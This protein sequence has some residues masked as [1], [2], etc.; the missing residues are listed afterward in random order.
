[1]RSFRGRRPMR[2]AIRALTG[3]IVVAALAAFA[4]PAAGDEPDTD[5][6]REATVRAAYD[7]AFP[8][9]FL[10]KLRWQ[11]LETSGGRT[12]TVL[13]QFAHSR[14]IAGPE[15]KWA[16]APLVDG[17]YSTAWIDLAQGPVFIDTP[18]TGNRYYVLTLIDFYSNTF[19]YMGTRTT[20]NKAQ[21]Q[22]LVGPDWDGRAPDAVPVVR[23]TTNDVYVNLR[24][25]TSG[26]ADQAAANAVQDGF[27]ITPA[28]GA[29]PRPAVPRVQPGNGPENYLAVV[30]QML[31]L[32]PPPSYDDSL[33]KQYR[34][35]G[36]CGEKCSFDKLPKPT[37]HTWREVYPS[38]GKYMEQYA[39]ATAQAK[40]WLDYSPPGSLLGTTEQRDYARRAL[41]IG[42][43]TGML[44]LRREEANYWITFTDGTGQHM[45][46]DKSY[47]LQLPQGGIPAKAFWSVTLYE[48]SQ[49]G[50][51][52]TPNPID[53]YHISS[54]SPGVTST[55][56]VD[57]WIQPQAPQDPAQKATWL[58][59]PANG[60]AFIL[61]ARAYIPGPAVISGEFKMPA[62]TLND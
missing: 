14:S 53:R 37:Q 51:F 36:I 52:L 2:A 18:D 24:V 28:P 20:G 12:S 49:A 23:A 55:G 46:G 25:Q 3:V 56:N 11:A 38:L 17:L 10:S 19:S 26:P 5:S 9:Y 30:N 6:H 47:K 22:L 58:P 29:T 61:F 21:R 27:G 1:M 43:G 34:K 16:N 7:Y 50:Q 60:K 48:V 32:N 35:A 41:S 33:I 59:A 57:I 44:G 62:V 39:A 4:P 54:D 42:S 15:D 13:N 45:T 31:T 40:S 8:L